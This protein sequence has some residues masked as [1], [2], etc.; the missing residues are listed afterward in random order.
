MLI[1]QKEII[2]IGG[3]VPGLLEIESGCVILSANLGWKNY[4]LKDRLQD[5]IRVPV[6]LNND[7]NI[8]TIGKLWKGS[9][10]EQVNVIF[11]TLVTGIGCGSIA[12]GCVLKAKMGLLV[13]LD[14]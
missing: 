13:K 7:A 1:T 4:F 6:V 2:R 11:I 12:E 14:I 5:K 10:Q 3:G 8:A 9:A